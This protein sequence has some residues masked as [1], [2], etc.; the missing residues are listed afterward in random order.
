M[1]NSYWKVVLV[2]NTVMDDDRNEQLDLTGKEFVVLSKRIGGRFDDRVF[3][4][5][6]MISYI[7]KVVP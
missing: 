3:I 2:D 1:A 5:K 4:R 7:E 6:S